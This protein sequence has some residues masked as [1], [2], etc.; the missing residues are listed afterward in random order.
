MK[1]AFSVVFLLA[2]SGLVTGSA[3]AQN[4]T[5]PAPSTQWTG[6]RLVY[7]A[8]TLGFVN[9][10]TAEI[11]VMGVDTIRGDPAL[12][13]RF[14]VQGGNML[15]RLN[16]RMDS[17]IRL[18]DFASLRFI[19]DNDE[20]GR[21]RRNAYE[22]FPDSGYYRQEGIDSTFATVETPLDDASFFYFVRTVPLEVGTNEFPLYFRPDRNPVVLE[23]IGR[24]TIS[25]P[26]GRFSTLVVRPI[27]KGGGI[28]REQAEGRMWI[29]DDDRRLVV[30]ITSKFSFATITMRLVR[31]EVTP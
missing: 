7:D 29:T 15:Y 12:H 1:S 14:L 9:L 25:V 6:E 10:G 13:I 3:V 27:I 21:R 20:G 17:W 5:I 16:N 22:I 19:Q 18:E 11:R 24:E 28:F 4:G 30:Q 31:K 2:V 26:A 8:R 23:V